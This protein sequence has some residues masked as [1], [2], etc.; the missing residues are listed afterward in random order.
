MA[1]IAAPSLA[2]STLRSAWAGV[3]LWPGLSS[4]VVSEVKLPAL[5]N[6][7]ALNA[8]FNCWDMVFMLFR[9][10]DG[11][12]CFIYCRIHASAHNWLITL[13]ID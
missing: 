5:V 10:T 9:G 13:K 2:A 12:R 6:S 7:R 11:S 4:I 3:V 8:C 1:P